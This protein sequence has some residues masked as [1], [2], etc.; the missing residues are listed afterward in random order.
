VL[1]KLKL[2]S[3]S[4]IADLLEERRTESPPISLVAKS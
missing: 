3:A 4:Q 1:R 2:R